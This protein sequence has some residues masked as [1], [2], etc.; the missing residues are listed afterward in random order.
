MREGAPAGFDAYDRTYSEA[1]NAA[2][3]FSGMKVDFFTRVKVDCFVSL[4]ESL[5]PPARSAEVI[6]VGCG[7]ANSH[8]LLAGRVGRLAGT[9]V[10]RA[11]I[12]RAAEQ[13]PG[14][15]YKHY[16]G[17][18]LPY[19]DE[20]FDAASAV[21][22][23]HHIPTAQRLPLARDIHRVLRAGGIFAVFEHNPL[24]PLTRHV[25]NRCEFDRDAVLLRKQEAEALLKDARFRDVQSRFILAVPPTGSILSGVDKLL[26]RIPLGAQYFTVGRA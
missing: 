2:L 6:D 19:P 11:C 15:E 13:N 5:R 16:D 9:D 18:S 24:N 25:V 8:P 26:A 4:I 7:V 17:S 23:L 21:C 22:V 10:S 14:N 12:S 3:G 20:S 1:V